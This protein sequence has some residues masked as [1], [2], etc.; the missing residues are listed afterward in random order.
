MPEGDTIFRAARTLHSVLAGRT[1]TRFESPRA[2]VERL[3]AR[4]HVVG[5]TVERV[6]ARGKHLL[7]RFSGGAVLHTHMRMHGSWHVYRRTSPWRRPA[8]AMRALVGAGEV[9]AVCFDAPVVELLSP[10]DEATHPALS[11]LGT[12]L[13]GSGFDPAQ[14]R[15]ALRAR[16]DVEI[17]VAL[18]D[19]RALAGIGNVYKSEVLFLCGVDPFRRV[20]SLDDAALDRLVLTAARQLRRNVSR[21][22][23]RTSEE[24][25]G[26]PLW[27]YRRKGRACRRCGTPVERRLQ[28]EQA[29]STYWCPG[30]QK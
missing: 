27:V 22:E 15:H 16:P 2:G 18:L 12:D 30:C 7:M 1:V 8:H 21:N 3:A 19:Q 14:A 23:R 25:G 5:G 4:L 6:E 17:G 10:G 29:R 9:L 11:G 28:G 20:A 26:P 13:L 24:L